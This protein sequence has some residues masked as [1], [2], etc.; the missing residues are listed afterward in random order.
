MKEV[1]IFAPI[2]TKLPVD[3]YGA[4]EKITLERAKHLRKLGYK[5]QIIANLEQTGIADEILSPNV[6]TKL[7][8]N[9]T[10]EMI[11]LATLKWR[12]YLAN[13][14]RLKDRIWDAPILSDESSIDPF[15]NYFLSKNMQPRKLLYYL[16]GNYYFSNNIS[17]YLFQPLDKVL[18]STSKTL[19]G[20]LNKHL[21]YEFEK[22]HLPAYYMPNGIV[23]PERESIEKNSNENY[24][25]FVGG[26]KRVKAP[27]I[28]IQIARK[29][30]MKLIIVG[31]IQEAAY[32]N[33]KVKPNLNNDIQYKGE[34]SRNELNQIFSHASAL[35]FTSEW[36]DPQP[37]VVLEAMSYGV[38]VLALN[39]GYYSGIYE[40][41]RNFKN[42]FIGSTVDIVNNYESIIN[43]RRLDVYDY[44]KMNWSWDYIL[45]KYHIPVIEKMR[46]AKVQ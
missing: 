39:Y 34:I 9:K 42:G 40:M 6:Y 11:W 22:R 27:H 21:L 33:E 25:L 23:F 19:Y 46:D 36:D 26:I 3:G 10:E 1:V 31:P 35:L 44:T 18:G 45:K 16:H 30:K 28:A 7:P 20:T 8:S 14:I 29:I 32:F 38:P 5:V 24:L 43:L 37:T 17:K 41:V 12:R 13:Y 15:D 4:I 2:Y